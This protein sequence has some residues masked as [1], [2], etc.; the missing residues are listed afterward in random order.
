VVV[1]HHLVPANP[2]VDT[3][4]LAIGDMVVAA[5]DALLDDSAGH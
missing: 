2:G 4:V 5:A 3:P 1:K